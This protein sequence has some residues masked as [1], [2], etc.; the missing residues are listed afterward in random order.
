MQRKRRWLIFSVAALVWVLVGGRLCWAG[1]PAAGKIVFETR[2]HGCHAALPYIG[3]VG[4]ANLPKFLANPRRFN[5]NTAMTFPGL[6][7]TKDID[8]VIAYITA[9][10]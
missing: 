3:R 2:C 5:P 10:R 4:E 7:S 1:D 9:P 6:R 8:D